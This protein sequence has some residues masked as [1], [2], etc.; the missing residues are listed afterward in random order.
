MSLIANPLKET[1]VVLEACHCPMPEFNLSHNYREYYDTT[2]NDIGERIKDA[3]IVITT[4][5]QIT[6]EHV[7]QAPHLRLLVVMGTGCA[8]VDAEYYAK[9]GVTVCN[10]PSSNIESVS[11]HTL[12]MY[13]ATRRR[14]LAMHKLVTETNEWHEQSSLTKLWD[15]GPPLSPSQE[16]VGIVGYGALGKAIKKLCHAVGMGKVVIAERKGISAEQLR[17]GRVSFENMVQRATVIIVCCP[18]APSTIDLISYN[19]LQE[20]RKDSILINVARGGIVNEQ[21]LANALKERKITGAATDVLEVEPAERG[22]SP[23]VPVDDEIP[24]LLISPHVSWFAQKTLENLQSLLK[25]AVEGFVGGKPVNI[26][27]APA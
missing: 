10:C 12:G 13:F 3:T 7:E 20:M 8:W 22:K 19:E 2:P 15:G 24:N 26:V 18:K 1:I 14:F 5:R 23:L 11:G 9:R 6:P 4:I 21:A 25:Q 27:V 17:E 16:I